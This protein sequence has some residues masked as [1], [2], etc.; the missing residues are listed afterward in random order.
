MCAIV[1]ANVTFE[2]FGNKR[3]EAGVRFRNWLDSG[4][5]MLVVGGRN[6]DELVQNGN[7]RRWFLEERRLGGRRLRQIRDE[8]IGGHQKA[9]VGDGLLTSDDEHVVALAQ[10][11]GARLLYS[12]DRQLKNDFLNAGIVREP[13]GR[14]YT[15]QDGGRFTSEHEELLR[16]ENL[17][18]GGLPD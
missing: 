6:L 16:T 14:V 9:L 11:S 12:N 15:T 4:R 3:T 8:S 1:D 7:F 17:C 13:A 18:G 10:V 2:V 5:G